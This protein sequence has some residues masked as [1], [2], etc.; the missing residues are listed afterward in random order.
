VIERRERISTGLTV[1]H[2][3]IEPQYQRHRQRE[4]GLAHVVSVFASAHGDSGDRCCVVVV[5]A[6]GG[7]REPAAAGSNSSTQDGRQESQ[8]LPERGQGRPS[9]TR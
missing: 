6:N 8:L 1:E 5:V 4:F 7:D 3:K 2:A 9:P